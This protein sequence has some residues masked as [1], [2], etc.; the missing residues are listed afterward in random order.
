MNAKNNLI[1][2][3]PAYEPPEGFIDYAKE[4]SQKVKTLI[5]V[6]D[7]SNQDFDNVFDEIAS[8]PNVEYIKYAKNQGKGY[9]LKQAF[10]FC[11]E[12]YGEKDVIVTADCDG[13]HKIKDIFNVFR[14]TTEHPDALVLGSRDFN[15]ANVPARSKAGNTS[16]RRIFSFF[17]GVKLYD[18]QTGLRGITV[19]TASRFLDVKGNRFEY[20]M[21]MLIYAKKHNISMLETPIDTV[22][23]EN[24]KDH[25]SHFKTIKDS[26]LVLGVV[27]SNLEWYLLSS[28]LSAILDILLFWLIAMVFVPLK[29]PALNTLVA[30]IVARIGSSI[31]NFTF[32]YK[33]VFNGSS[34]RSIFRYY[35]LW[36]CQ[37]GASYGLAYLFGH[38]IGWNITVMKA[39]CDLMLALISYQ[40]Q[41]H[42]VFAEKKGKRKGFY[43]KL[44]NF[45]RG[46]F[47]LFKKPYR[48][49]VIES[50]EPVVYVCR[51]LN[52]HAQWTTLTWLPFDV[53]PFALATFFDEKEATKHYRDYTFSERVGRKKKKYSIKASVSGWFVP[54][55]LRSLKCVPVY[56][57]S[58]GALNTFRSAMTFLQKGESLIVYVDVDYTASKETVSEIYS[59]FLGLGEMYCKKTGQSLRFVPLYI[60]DENKSIT[61]RPYV[62]ADNFKEAREG[63]THYLKN[64]INGIEIEPPT[65]WRAVEVTTAE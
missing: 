8:F 46:F 18:A 43:G 24:P 11:I 58:A 14:V 55:L 7:G 56:R 19:A 49:N 44:A 52:M 5:V 65:A 10:K 9:A 25:I 41:N 29:S 22:Y 48:V 33:F 47:R 3:I 27:L 53:H 64:A 61:E 16:I 17:Y 42:W 57:K 40:I 34:K 35:I 12:R 13:Q 30:T 28:T 6:N 62:L 21:A 15:Q 20:E 1:V 45:T 31:L 60:D 54:K 51:H 32:N 63:A 23:P 39:L 50:K 2:V 37:L 59:G 4:V 38:V 26:L 36:T